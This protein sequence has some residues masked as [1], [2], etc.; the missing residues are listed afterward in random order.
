MINMTLILQ[1]NEIRYTVNVNTLF[2]DSLNT[3]ESNQNSL[4][5]LRFKKYRFIF[6]WHKEKVILDS[7]ISNHGLE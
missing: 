3:A 6:F 5:L 1:T 4:K 7:K 2:S